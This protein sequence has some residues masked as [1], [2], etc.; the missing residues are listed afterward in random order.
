MKLRIR[1]RRLVDQIISLFTWSLVLPY[2]VSR[3]SQ[4]IKSDKS[5]HWSEMCMLLFIDKKNT[6]PIEKVG[7][8]HC[9][10]C[11]FLLSPLTN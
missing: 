3:K 6:R 1:L 2:L 9:I 11:L 7:Y 5:D 4:I 8:W 10:I